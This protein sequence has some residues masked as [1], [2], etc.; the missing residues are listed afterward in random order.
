MSTEV[1]VLTCLSIFS[2]IA[3][4]VLVLLHLKR[5]IDEEHE[6]NADRYCVLLPHSY[7]LLGFIGFCVTMTALVISSIM[8]VNLYIQII[9][10][11]FAVLLILF[12]FGTCLYR[13]VFVDGEIVKH[14]IFSK[15]KLN[16]SDITQ[17]KSLSFGYCTK[18]FTNDKLA[19][20]VN[21]DCIGVEYLQNQTTDIKEID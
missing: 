12:V 21:Q 10:G 9:I 11:L 5:I 14:T 20:V 6:N 8:Q 2:C 7:A 18:Y 3:M 16:L 15:K 1:I 19:F 4:C 13:L 17:K